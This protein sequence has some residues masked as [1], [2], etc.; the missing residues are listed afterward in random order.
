MRDENV[1][2][3]YRYTDPSRNEVIYIG[4]GKNSGQG[5]NFKRSKH[6][7]K[8]TDMHPFVQRLQLMTREGVRPVID[9]LIEGID[10]ELAD[11]IEI[12]AIDKYG[13]K[14]LGKGTLL[15]LNDGGN[16]EGAK[17]TSETVAKIAAGVKKSWAKDEI[18]LKHSEARKKLWADPA[19]RKAR[20]VSLEPVHESRRH[21]L[22]IEG[23]IYECMRVASEVLQL[24]R[25][26][27]AY[28]LHSD[29]YPEWKNLTKENK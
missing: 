16:G 24:P 7:L 28:R 5:K 11:L 1:K 14:D 3:I 27:I 23:V 18:R 12:E 10:Q 22:L 19:H 15:N 6:H 25:S 8:R 21:A 9:I 13:R 26:T 17:R 20:L 29:N 2:Y 4:Q